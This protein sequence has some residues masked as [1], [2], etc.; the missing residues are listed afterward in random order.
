MPQVSSCIYRCKTSNV[1]CAQGSSMRD[2]RHI[3]C[4]RGVGE[5]W[6]ADWKTVQCLTCF[7]AG[8]KIRSII[9]IKQGKQFALG[10]IY[11]RRYHLPS[12][13][14][15]QSCQVCFRKILPELVN[16]SCAEFFSNYD[17]LSSSTVASSYVSRKLI[18]MSPFSMIHFF[19]CYRAAQ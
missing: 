16:Q 19:V 12:V 3:I 14:C 9:S 7:T 17:F 18:K 13:T 2:W 1:R 4:Y 5:I 10:C 11:Q 8:L 6:Y 15:A